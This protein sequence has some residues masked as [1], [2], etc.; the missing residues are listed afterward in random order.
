MFSRYIINKAIEGFNQMMDYQQSKDGQFELNIEIEK[1]ND[2]CWTLFNTYT[3]TCNF[4]CNQS[5][6]YYWKKSKDGQNPATQTNMLNTFEH[7]YKNYWL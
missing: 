1:S 3:E 2:G 5:C 4:R 7:L 6:I